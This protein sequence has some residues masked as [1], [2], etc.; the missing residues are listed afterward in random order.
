MGVLSVFGGL[1]TLNSGF[2]GIRIIS[3]SSRITG[4][5][6]STRLITGSVGSPLPVRTGPGVVSGGG[7]AAGPSGFMK[8]AL[9]VMNVLMWISCITAVLSTAYSIIQHFREPDKDTVRFSVT[10]VDEKTGFI[11]MWIQL[12]D[13]SGLFIPGIK[14]ARGQQTLSKAHE[15]YLQNFVKNFSGE[16]SVSS[17]GWNEATQKYDL[18]KKMDRLTVNSYDTK[19][20]GAVNTSGGN[21]VKIGT[22]TIEISRAQFQADFRNILVGATSDND[23]KTKVEDLLAKYAEAESFDEDD[24]ECADCGNFN[25]E[26]YPDEIY[27]VDAQYQVKVM[28]A[29]KAQLAVYAAAGENSD[30]NDSTVQQRLFDEGY[31]PAF[32]TPKNKVA[33]ATSGGNIP[34]LPDGRGGSLG[35]PTVNSPQGSKFIAGVCNIEWDWVPMGDIEFA[36]S[37]IDSIRTSNLT[38]ITFTKENAPDTTLD[39]DFLIEHNSCS[40]PYY[41]EGGALP[42][43]GYSY[44]DTNRN[45]KA[46]TDWNDNSKI[47]SEKAALGLTD[48]G[49]PTAAAAGE[50]TSTGFVREE[51]DGKVAY[52]E[53][54]HWGNSAGATS[55]A[56]IEPFVFQGKAPYVAYVSPRGARRSNLNN[57][58][59]MK[60]SGIG[61]PKNV[62]GFQLS[63]SDWGISGF[64]APGWK[65]CKSQD[66][67]RTAI[68]NHIDAVQKAGGTVI[69]TGETLPSSKNLNH[70]FVWAVVDEPLYTCDTCKPKDSDGCS[71]GSA[72]GSDTSRNNFYIGLPYVLAIRK[73]IRRAADEGGSANYEDI[74]VDPS[75]MGGLGKYWSVSNTFTVPCITKTTPKMPLIQ[76]GNPR[77]LINATPINEEDE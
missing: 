35:T 43:V 72:V 59:H 18:N 27:C 16:K 51:L 46:F 30:P 57:V 20:R 68:Q 60:R 24:N 64:K 50:I 77:R 22:S 53:Y 26:V 1:G 31:L 52:P 14:A 74:E 75:E 3:T 7:G 39:F 66:A 42:D 48:W 49:I 44:T 5:F 21:R 58:L 13:F 33:P 47:N 56:A 73:Q 40:D 8:T 4:G 62:G 6:S 11:D 17:G 67:A 28:S 55:S 19:G 2:G 37:E 34:P 69:G 41:W 23:L 38:Q 36:Y 25:L 12:H 10:G 54:D 65:R 76:I 15:Q 9:K 45:E 70:F 29:A 61:L 63:E 32:L 71:A